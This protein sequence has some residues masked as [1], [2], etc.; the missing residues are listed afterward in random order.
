MG[1]LLDQKNY[2]I[3]HARPSDIR[4]AVDLTLLDLKEKSVLQELEARWWKERGTKSETRAPRIA[5][6]SQLELSV[7]FCFYVCRRQLSCAIAQ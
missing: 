2:G 1:D 5:L 7:L 6:V 3:A 4:A